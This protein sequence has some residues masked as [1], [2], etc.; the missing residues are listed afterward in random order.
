MPPISGNFQSPSYNLM[1]SKFMTGIRI[2][3]GSAQRAVP[4][5]A[6]SR[7]GTVSPVCEGGRRDR[8]R[9]SFEMD[10]ACYGPTESPTPGTSSKYAMAKDRN[11]A[12]SIV[13]N[14][15]G[16]VLQNAGLG[17]RAKGGIYDTIINYSDPNSSFASNSGA[18]TPWNTK[19][20]TSAPLA[21]AA[22]LNTTTSQVQRFSGR[23]YASEAPYECRRTKTDVG[24][25]YG[26]KDANLWAQFSE[27]LAVSA[28]FT[29]CPHGTLYSKLRN[30]VGP[31]DT[32]RMETGRVF[33]KDYN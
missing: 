17:T 25:P 5:N 32:G 33:N 8:F 7:A 13:R 31:T 3:R 26:V 22:K 27:K 2:N 30:D 19:Q 16:R 10:T 20:Q 12:A 29:D 4:F 23:G 6:S 9:P 1:Q 28:P 11:L 14:P 18:L 21:F 24:D 15:R